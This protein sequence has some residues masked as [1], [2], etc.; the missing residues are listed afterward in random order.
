MSNASFTEIGNIASLW[1]YPVKSM[2]GEELQFTKVTDRGLSGD[3]SYA[4]LDHVDGKIATAKNPRKWP[5]LFTF[6]AKLHEVMH[7]TE[8]FSP[9][10]ITLPDGTN[11][12]SKQAD[13]DQV[14]SK[15]LNRQVMLVTTEHRRVNGVQSSLPTF[16]TPNSEEYWPDVDGRDHRDTFTDFTLPSGTFFDASMVHLLTTTAL[17]QLRACYPDGDFAVQRFRPNIVVEPTRE[18]RGFIES[19][20][21]GHSLTIGNDVRLNIT[22]PCGRCVMTTLAQGNL[23]K[24]PGILRAAIKHNRGNVGVYA[25]V[26]QGGTIYPSDQVRLEQAK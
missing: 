6:Q 22:G 20:W 16:W 21:I 24:N 3:R 18:T 23:P 26:T 7:E 25:V 19:S 2:L 13:L 15:T 10:H 11:V 9:V 12:T 8:T 17:N 1:R 14:L 4:I 5:T